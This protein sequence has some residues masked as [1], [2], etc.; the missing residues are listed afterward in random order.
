MFETRNVNLGFTGSP[1]THDNCKL[2]VWSWFFQQD[3]DKKLESIDKGE[4]SLN[5]KPEACSSEPDFTEHF[6]CLSQPETKHQPCGINSGA[7]VICDGVFAGVYIGNDGA[8]ACNDQNPTETFTAIR[9]DNDF[10]SR[11]VAETTSAAD[12]FDEDAPTDE[13]PPDK[14]LKMCGRSDNLRTSLQQLLIVTI[15]LIM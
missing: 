5:V 12:L 4:L 9:V 1:P 7:P 6:L 2:V 11:W 13:E 8:V 14:I 3:P 10:V 15:V